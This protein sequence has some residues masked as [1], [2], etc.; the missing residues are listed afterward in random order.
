M[1]E[2][3]AHPAMLMALV[4]HYEQDAVDLSSTHFKPVVSQRRLPSNRQQGLLVAAAVQS[5]QSFQSSVPGR[6][7]P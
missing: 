1:S 6:K 3:N 2:K 5:P 7:P 4:G